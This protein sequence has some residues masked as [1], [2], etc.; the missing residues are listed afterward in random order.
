M[1]GGLH[2]AVDRASARRAQR[3]ASPDGAKSLIYG[4]R[5]NGIE[6]RRGT[7]TGKSQL[8]CPISP[9]LPRTKTG[10]RRNDA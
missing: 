2:V 7:E 1:E 9:E 5:V 3:F 4:D 8:N 10:V 6:P